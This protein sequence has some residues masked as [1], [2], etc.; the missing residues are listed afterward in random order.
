M[1]K[2]VGNAKKGGSAAVH[3]EGNDAGQPA[4]SSSKAPSKDVVKPPDPSSFFPKP[5]QPKN[6]ASKQASAKASRNPTQPNSPTPPKKPPAK[7]SRAAS[8]AAPSPGP[9]GASTPKDKVS[10]EEKKHPAEHRPSRQAAKDVKRVKSS[11]AEWGWS[12]EPKAARNH[13]A[14]GMGYYGAYHDSWSPQNEFGYY[15]AYGEWRPEE[16]WPYYAPYGIEPSAPHHPFH[17]A[18]SRH[19]HRFPSPS[20]PVHGH[21][22]HRYAPQR[23]Q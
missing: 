23:S 22:S 21:L 14:D 2:K 1:A 12:V 5:E 18:N 4:Q 11:W 9:A 13:E 7:K 10:P 16:E 3:K 19:R 8:S 17:H 15:G 20:C 6:L